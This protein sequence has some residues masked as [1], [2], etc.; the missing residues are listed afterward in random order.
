[1]CVCGGGLLGSEVCMCA[2]WLWVVT[3]AEWL[4]NESWTAA[5]AQTYRVRAFLH[6][7]WGGMGAVRW[8][9]ALHVPK[10]CTALAHA[11]SPPPPHTPIPIHFPGAVRTLIALDILRAPPHLVCAWLQ[12]A[13]KVVLC[14][15][16][17]EV[18]M[19]AWMTYVQ[20]AGAFCCRTGVWRPCDPPCH[21]SP[22]L[23]PPHHGA[24]PE[25]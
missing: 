22:I 16:P 7:G 3:S 9:R 14:A 6:G 15:E 24:V 10:L 12:E 13:V 2:C 20:G 4:R 8:W 17:C 11:H 5:G 18:S 19:L 23:V 1:V 25:S 21:R